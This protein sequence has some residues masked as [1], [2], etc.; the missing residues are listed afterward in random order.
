M[1]DSG[2]RFQEGE[3]MSSHK[4]SL[5]KPNKPVWAIGQKNLKINEEKKFIFPEPVE[6]LCMI[7]ID[8]KDMASEKNS[9]T[10]EDTRKNNFEKGSVQ[11]LFNGSIGNPNA[12]NIDMSNS[13]NNLN[14][15]K[16]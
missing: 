14:P 7:C 5:D 15:K 10:S 16:F 4:G 3:P 1:I 11:P 6:P 13:Q 2:F 8:K 12:H 9:F